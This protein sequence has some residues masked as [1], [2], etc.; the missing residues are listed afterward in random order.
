MAIASLAAVSLC[1]F[2]GVDALSFANAART[3][4]FS[5]QR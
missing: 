3:A 5:A 2:D 4:A 1:S